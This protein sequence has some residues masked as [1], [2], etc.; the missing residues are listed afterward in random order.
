MDLAKYLLILFYI[1][2]QTICIQAQDRPIFLPEDIEGISS[3]EICFCK[4]GVSNTSKTRG[5]EL[6]YLQFGSSTLEEEEGFP[7]SNDLSEF[8]LEQIN[9]KLR[10]PIVNKEGFKVIGGISYRPERYDFEAI[11]SDYQSV[12]E[13]LDSRTLKS[14]G[15]GLIVSKSLNEKFYAILSLRVRYNGNYD[16]LID[17]SDKF[18]IYQV[19]GVF[20]IKRGPDKEFAFGLNF[21]HSFRSTTVIPFI[22]YNR[23][24][25]KSWGIEAVL[26]SLIKLRY[27]I[28]KESL[29]YFSLGYNS[30]SYA[31]GT[32]N[33][34][35]DDFNLNHS[36]VRASL[37]LEQKLFSWIWLDLTGGLQYNFTTDFESLDNSIGDFEVEPGLAPYFKIG[38]FVTPPDSFMK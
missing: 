28:G 2:L 10:F 30:E 26:P 23:T 6:S 31:I 5:V 11:G 3:K 33:E 32:N 17:I 14:S 25:N 16:G 15:L 12:F 20:G 22:I 4:P 35:L 13:F 19:A 37:T 8:K 21:S 7:L 34:L 38:L 36:E 18:G 29:S 1:S 9:F 27:N 24:F